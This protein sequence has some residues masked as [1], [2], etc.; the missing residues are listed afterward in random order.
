[1]LSQVVGSVTFFYSL[2]ALDK[3]ISEER[4]EAGCLECEGPLHRASYA[5]KAAGAAPVAEGGAREAV[6][7][8]LCCGQCRRRALPPSV[9]FFGRRWYVYPTILLATILCQGRVTGRPL[10]ALQ[11]LLGVSRK[12]LLRWVE[13]FREVFPRSAPWQAIRG[14]FG[15]AVRDQELPWSLLASFW[16]ECGRLDEA[17]VRYLGHLASG[18]GLAEGGWYLRGGWLCG[19]RKGMW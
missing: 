17:L 1:M 12:T 5:R 16:W 14:R 11:A 19:E 10:G 4:R 8:G 9:L 18:T 13:Y 6:R 15:A 2:Q 3:Q 7:Y